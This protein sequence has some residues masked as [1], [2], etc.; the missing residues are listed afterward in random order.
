M[1]SKQYKFYENERKICQDVYL[2]KSLSFF[3]F[4]LKC[5]FNLSVSLNC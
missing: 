2:E 5:I 4:K 1:D 3:M